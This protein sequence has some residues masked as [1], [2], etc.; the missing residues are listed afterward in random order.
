MPAD[1]WSCRDLERVLRSE[2]TEDNNFEDWDQN[3]KRNDCEG[4]KA[5]VHDVMIN[6]YMLPT[7]P[8]QGWLTLCKVALIYSKWKQRFPCLMVA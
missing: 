6:N 8:K 5:S 7:G 4:V 2:K 3:G 1:T